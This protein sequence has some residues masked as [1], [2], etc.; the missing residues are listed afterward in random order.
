MRGMDMHYV[1]IGNSAA[2]I[3]AVE[4]IRK[5]DREGRIT[6]ISDEAY[7]T[8]SRPLISYYLAG[9]IEE[10]QLIYR[11]PDF[12]VKNSVDT[13]LGTKV[14]QI[15]C[16]NQEVV[17]ENQDRLRYDRLLIAAGGKPFIPQIEGLDKKGIYSFLKLDDVKQ[18]GNICTEGVKAVVIGAGLIGLKAAE[19]LGE[20][21]VEVTVVE[22]ADRVL[23]TIL[24]Q[25][26]AEMVQKHLEL[27]GINF[28]LNNTV[29]SF[30]G[31]ENVCS[32]TLND[33]TIVEC[34]FAV[35]AIGVIPNTGIVGGTPIQTNRG[36]AVDRFMRTNI[37]DVYAAGDICEGFDSL[38][39][40]NRVIPILPGAYMQGE[41]AGQNMAGG[42]VEYAGGFA[43][44]SI[45]FFG[46]PMITAGIGTPDCE[47]YEI[48]VSSVPENGIYK[49]VVL[50]DDKICG[51]IYLGNIDRVG[52]L[53]NLIKERVDV[54]TFR[55]GILTDSF[56]LASFPGEYRKNKML[57]EKAVRW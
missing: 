40:M 27:H 15:D 44:N 17:L 45:G 43:M 10:S 30:N 3:G 21:K 20:L 16:G 47:G 52:I 11:E 18:I 53:T 7:H 49:K 35:T 34:D 25:T 36:I 2:A 5:L 51:F 37:Q 1:I 57:G 41:T 29:K 46:L 8:Y 22:L 55:D 24:D 13:I 38:H 33:E 56:G 6:L 12:Y 48:M 19:A 14:V 9:K 4:G 54:S 42:S 26:A 39:N 32:V 31:E 28:I 50:K 23:S